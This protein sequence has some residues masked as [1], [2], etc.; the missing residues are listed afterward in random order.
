MSSPTHDSHGRRIQELLGAQPDAG[1]SNLVAVTHGVLE[2]QSRVAMSMF[3]ADQDGQMDLAVVF[4]A[5]GRAEAHE[6]DVLLAAL[7]RMLDQMDPD[8]SVTAAAP[9]GAD[10]PH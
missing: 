8:R 10:G 1:L 5:V 6:V 2:L 3:E 7:R 9:A 4:A